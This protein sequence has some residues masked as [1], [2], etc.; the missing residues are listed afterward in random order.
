MTTITPAELHAADILL[1]QGTDFPIDTLI[2]LF[3][4][5]EYSHS[6]IY[7]GS[8]VL[9]AIATGI[10]LRDL[11]TSVANTDVDVFRF[12][13]NDHKA[14]GD[15]NYPAAPIL[16]RIAHYRAEHARYAYEALLLLALLTTT[17]RARIP[18]MGPILRHF[19]DEAAA[20]ADVVL[21]K[22]TAA[23]KQ[24]MICSELVYRCYAEAG[25]KYKI[26]VRGADMARLHVTTQFAN[27][28][29]ASSVAPAVTEPRVSD[30]PQSEE[31]FTFLER[32]LFAKEIDHP[33]LTAKG[34]QPPV[35]ANFVTPRDLKGSFNLNNIG[36]LRL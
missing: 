34:T 2:R 3:D 32:Y 4:G 26:G 12:V 13:S 5:S 35:V 23:G 31:A 17:R 1:Y 8:R 21:A 22:L 11:A 6:S 29:A 30:E 10:E 19:L 25:D 28:Y 18:A 9:E 36:R 27:Y 24:P 20:A 33:S 7:D 14:I 16:G 15:P